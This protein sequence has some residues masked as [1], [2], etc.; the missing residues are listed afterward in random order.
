MS[1]EEVWG[2]LEAGRIS[3]ETRVWR[4]GFNTWL[5]VARVA[6][7]EDAFVAE[8]AGSPVGKQPSEPDIERVSVPERSESRPCKLTRRNAAHSAPAQDVTF[9]TRSAPADIAPA[10][11]F[12]ARRSRPAWLAPEL[13]VFVTAFVISAGAMLTG[14]ALLTGL[15]RSEVPRVRRVAIDVAEHANQVADRA[16]AQALERETAWWQA[17]WR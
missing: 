3:T 9:G 8:R 15:A 17:R 4:D 1:T 7:L 10:N 12:V 11:A 16:Q 5:E 14:A 6:E 2:E 13:R